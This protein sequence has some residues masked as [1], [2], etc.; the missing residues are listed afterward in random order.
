MNPAR[1]ILLLLVA[2][3]P[4]SLVGYG[5]YAQPVRADSG[6]CLE[7]CCCN[8][9]QCAC[10]H[11]PEPQPPPTIPAGEREAPCKPAI[12]ERVRPDI[13]CE[14]FAQLRILA[15]PPTLNRAI[16]VGQRLSLLCLWLT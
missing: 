12:L 5:L 1:L 6:C 13:A 15:H 9:S 11:T 4:A 3:Q 14:P 10:E 8:R 16:K 7:A 2:L